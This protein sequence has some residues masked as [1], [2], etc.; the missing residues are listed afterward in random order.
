MKRRVRICGKKWLNTEIFTL[1]IRLP[2]ISPKPGQFFQVRVAE[3]LDPFLNRPI[4]IASYEKDTLL[5]VI[6]VVGRGTALLSRKTVDDEVTLIGPFGTGVQPKKKNSLLIAGGIGVA[7]MY[8]LAQRLYKRKT[9]FTFVYGAKTAAGLVLK[10]GIR[11]HATESVFVTE[12]GRNK[13]TA[14]DALRTLDAREYSVAYACGPRAMLRSL[15]KMDLG[16]PVYA[17]CEDFL[18]C[19]CGL[20]LGCAILY[21]GQYKRICEDGPV[22]ELSGINFDA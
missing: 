17:F 13:T 2:G 14:V 6:K 4:S 1:R 20:C 5:L 22:F 10:E 8:F 3:T 16:I 11:K 9:P 15:Q 19:G 7:P 21:R 12:Q 18:G